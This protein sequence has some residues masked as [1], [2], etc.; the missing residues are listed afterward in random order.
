MVYPQSVVKRYSLPIPKF[1][2]GYWDLCCS[3]QA[4]IATITWDT[5]KTTVTGATFVLSV[6]CD[7]GAVVLDGALNGEAIPTQT[8]ADGEE[9]QVRTCTKSFDIRNGTNLVEIWAC[10]IPWL[11]L[12]RWLGEAY[13]TVLDCYIE[14]TF[15]G[16]APSRPWNELIGEWFSANWLSLA[17]ASA[18]LVGGV[19]VYKT[20]RR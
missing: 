20:I 1:R 18:V 19:W 3:R 17:V 2:I 4:G 5:A 15:E 8:W 9:G 7:H 6:L 14:V 13:L 11:G 16:E 12:V 10:K